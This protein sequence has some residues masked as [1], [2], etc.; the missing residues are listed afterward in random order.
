MKKF[1]I[2]SM[3]GIMLFSDAIFS[4]G[5]FASNPSPEGVW[6]KFSLIFHRPKFNCERGFGI[7][8]DI[9]YGFTGSDGTAEPK[10]CAVRGQINNLNQLVVEIKESALMGYE[11]GSTL[12]YFK[13]KKTITIADPYTFSETTC[14][15]LGLKSQF[16]IK[17]G[18]Y[19]VI[20]KDGL[21]IVVFQP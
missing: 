10:G 11:G 16:T 12:S 20:F 5:T 13:D 1:I 9:D 19:P 15:S 21:Y 7:C 6:I 4:T 8:F 3:L 2:L 18:E 14:K 17:P